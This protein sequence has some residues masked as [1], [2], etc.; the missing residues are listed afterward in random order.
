MLI[1]FLLHT[2]HLQIFY[3]P[4]KW[5]LLQVL[6]LFR[7]LHRIRK[8]IFREDEAMLR[9]EWVRSQEC[10]INLRSILKISRSVYLYLSSG[11]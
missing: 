8:D 1:F 4:F 3:I 9:S 5:R 10:E 6:S 11:M 2:R 7:D